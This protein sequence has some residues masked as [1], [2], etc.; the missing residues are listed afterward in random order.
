MILKHTLVTYFRVL[1]KKGKIFHTNYE[2][3]RK[4]KLK[5]EK[6]KS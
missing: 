1:I 2:K 3:S 4:P 5:T 6:Q